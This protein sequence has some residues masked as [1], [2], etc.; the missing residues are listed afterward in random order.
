[1]LLQDDFGTSFIVHNIKSPISK[2]L[3][4]EVPK[5]GREWFCIPHPILVSAKLVI[6]RAI[7][8]SNIHIYPLVLV[9]IFSFTITFRCDT[10]GYK[11]EPVPFSM[12]LWA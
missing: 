1:V 4:F 7:F 12:A 5:R 8:Y 11:K 2:M 3:E 10:I 9:F 6:A